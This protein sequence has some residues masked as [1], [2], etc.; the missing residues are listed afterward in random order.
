MYGRC[1][2]LF[3]GLPLRF[4]RVVFLKPKDERNAPSVR[5]GNIVME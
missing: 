3:K 4:I 1:G 2:S 5:V